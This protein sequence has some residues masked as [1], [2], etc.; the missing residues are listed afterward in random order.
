[1][2]RVT[3][4]AA[5]AVGPVSPPTAPARDSRVASSA[6]TV[7]TAIETCSPSVRETTMLP[8]AFPT[9]AADQ[10][11]LIHRRQSRSTLP[12]VLLILIQGLSPIAENVNDLVPRLKTSIG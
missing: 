5:I 12:E 4:T 7:E 8:S 3:S 9:G 11:M 1:M 2:L 10:S 6:R